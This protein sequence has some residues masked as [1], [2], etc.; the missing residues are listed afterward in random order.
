MR[1]GRRLPIGLAVLMALALPAGASAGE[2]PTAI[3]HAFDL[4]FRQ[5]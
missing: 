2:Q 5:V 1:F 4:P 3:L